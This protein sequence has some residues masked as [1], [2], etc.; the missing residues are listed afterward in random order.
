MEATESKIVARPAATTPTPST[1]RKVGCRHLPIHCMVE[2]STGNYTEDGS[3]FYQLE[4]DDYTLVPNDLPVSNLP[5]E[6]LI[7]LGYTLQHSS[8]V[9]GFIQIVNWKPLTLECITDDPRVSVDYLFANLM[10]VAT[11]RIQ[12]TS[13]PSVVDQLRVSMSDGT[14]PIQSVSLTSPVSESSTTTSLSK[15]D[16]PMVSSV[17]LSPSIPPQSPSPQQQLLI[18]DIKEKLDSLLKN[19]KQAVLVSH[20]CPFSQAMISQIVLG[21]YVNKIS[22]EKS[23]AFYKWH[24]IYTGLSKDSLIPPRKKS[25]RLRRM[26]TLF[27]PKQELPRLRRWFA[28]NSR[29]SKEQMLMLEQSIKTIVQCMMIIMDQTLVT[30]HL[31]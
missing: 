30:N 28:D 21:K 23:R 16:S 7:Q 9:T 13:N 29:P 31:Q 6:A 1:E 11:L 24:E 14:P 20:G 15:P 18:L 4:V 3:P 5:K 26:R 19:H 17:E 25:S 8:I 2:V 27:D 22:S 10:N 12:I